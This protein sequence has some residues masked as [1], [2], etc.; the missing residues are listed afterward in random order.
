MAN[1]LNYVRKVVPKILHAISD[2]II[3]TCITKFPFFFIFT[4]GRG[5]CGNSLM[6]NHD[7][8]PCTMGLLWNFVLNSFCSLSKRPS[9]SNGKFLVLV[10]NIEKTFSISLRLL[11]LV[12]SF[13]VYRL[14]PFYLG[15]LS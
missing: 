6:M 10:L 11:L 9:R 8:I 12:I 3:N 14:F 13:A 4:I 2:G 15:N 1:V 5:E 7:M